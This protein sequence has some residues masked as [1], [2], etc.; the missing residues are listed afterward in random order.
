MYIYVYN[1]LWKLVIKMSEGSSKTRKWM[2]HRSD[3]KQE[4]EDESKGRMLPPTKKTINP[5]PR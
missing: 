3:Y 5:C 2:V 1:A 4:E